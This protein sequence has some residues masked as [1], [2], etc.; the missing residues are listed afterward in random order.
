MPSPSPNWLSTLAARPLWWRAARIALP[1]GLLQD[2]INQG[3]H[4]LRGDF[5]AVVV[6]KSVLTPCVAFAVAL[7]S[8]AST[9]RHFQS[10]S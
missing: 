6:A 4:W 7:V 2:C 5:S 3:D 9:S 1:V 8:A 10:K